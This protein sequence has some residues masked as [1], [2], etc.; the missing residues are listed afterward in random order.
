MSKP[1]IS[2]PQK[3]IGRLARGVLIAATAALAACAAPPVSPTD[4]A[5]AQARPVVQAAASVAPATSGYKVSIAN[6]TFAAPSLTV[7]VGATVTWTNDDDV[8]HTVVSADRKTF[9]SKTLDTDQSFSFTFTAAGEYSYFC[10]IHPM[11]TGKIIVTA[12]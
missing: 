11:M 10:S 4:A 7:P 6:F 3:L 9:R 12:G 2:E 5:A 1:M 8:P